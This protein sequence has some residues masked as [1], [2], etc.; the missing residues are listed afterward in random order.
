[1]LPKPHQTKKIVRLIP[2][3][4]FTRTGCRK[5]TGAKVNT[6]QASTTAN[7]IHSLGCATKR[8]EHDHVPD[9]GEALEEVLLR[10]HAHVGIVDRAGDDDD[11]RR[12][13]GEARA[14][15]NPLW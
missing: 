10:L 13:E 9:H 15:M 4:R 8:V 12:Q 3:S 6:A 11:R 2:R 5:F 1:M 14:P 7:D